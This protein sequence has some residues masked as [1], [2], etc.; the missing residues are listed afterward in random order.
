MIQSLVYVSSSAVDPHAR[1][2]ALDSIVGA[3]RRNNP[4][5]DL[6]GALV[7]TGEHFV[8]V[9]EGDPLSIRT[10]FT[11]LRADPRHHSIRVVQKRLLPHRSF[12]RWAMAYAGPSVFVS[13]HIGRLLNDPSPGEATRATNWLVDFLADSAPS[14]DTGSE[15]ELMIPTS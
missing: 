4:R 11:T 7:F 14:V 6:T 1:Q 5:C 3:S 2:E 10:L 15:L 13:R 8:Q 12:L 9:L